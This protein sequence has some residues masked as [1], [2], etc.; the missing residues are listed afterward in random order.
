MDRSGEEMHA[1]SHDSFDDEESWGTRPR[2]DRL[3]RP[4]TI[5][6]SGRSK[7]NNESIDLTPSERSYSCD[8]SKG[9]AGMGLRSE[10]GE[11]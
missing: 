7:T 10:D 4:P 11:V 1:L 6:R 3:P 8:A 5:H 2:R 9:D